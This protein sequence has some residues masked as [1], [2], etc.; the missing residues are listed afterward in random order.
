MP[1]T[2]VSDLDLVR[3]LRWG[4]TEEERRSLVWKEWLVTNG[5]GG[6]ASGTVSGALTRRFHG[7]LIAALPNPFGRTMMLNYVWERLRFPD[8]RLVSLQ[9]VVET[10][11]GIEL[12]A[13]G[14][15]A[16]FRLE[17]GLPVWE[18]DIDGVR[19]EKRVLM[20]HLQNTT[21]VSYRLLSSQPIRLELR[22]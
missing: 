20:P 15:L 13:S 1:M 6:Y 17:M 5:L 7:L 14:V 22:P 9:Q 18:Y 4:H 3:P 19:I 2:A 11:S 16:G 8:G 21:H 12:D 10:A